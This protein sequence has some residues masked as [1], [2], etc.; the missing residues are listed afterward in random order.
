VKPLVLK[1]YCF[2]EDIEKLVPNQGA[3][4]EESE[5]LVPNLGC[6]EDVEE[7]VLKLGSFEEVKK[8]FQIYVLIKKTLENWSQN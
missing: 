5:K 4:E 2:E 7:L 1:Q 3:Y 6:Y 8:W